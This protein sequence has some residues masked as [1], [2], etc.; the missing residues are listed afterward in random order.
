M[1]Q[2]DKYIQFTN[3]LKKCHEQGQDELTLSFTEIE[4]IW[5][6]PLAR[7]MRKYSWA[8][9]RTQSYALGWLY[10]DFTVTAC[11]LSAETVTFA[12]TPEKV[13]TLLSGQHSRG[14]ETSASAAKLPSSVIAAPSASEVEKYLRAW[15]DSETYR[16]QESALNKLFLELAPQNDRI[17]NILIKAATLN[18][19]YST[20]IFSIYPVARHILSLDVDKRLQ[21]H[22]L[23]LVSD[24]SYVTFPNGKTKKLYSFATKYCSHHKP[25]VYPIYDDYI[26]KVLRY[27][28][29]VDGFSKFT[30]EMLSDYLSFN[31]ILHDFQLF[32]KLE[33][34]TLKEID[35]YLWQLG[36]ANFPKKYY[37]RVNDKRK[38]RHIDYA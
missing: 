16:L 7:S 27:Y 17:E 5:G 21:A 8:N 14:R 26:S 6:F 32:Y 35:Q 28:R 2:G 31:T 23:S 18:D 37:R 11:D 15:N 33:K 4:R 20:N 30:N 3:Y 19:F 13:S 10:A 36:K 12:Y 25:D 1:P 9:D 29:D 38:G 34:Y 24:L 22:D